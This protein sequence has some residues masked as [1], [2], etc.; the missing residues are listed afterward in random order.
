VWVTNADVGSDSVTRLAASDGT[1]IGT[2]PVG[3]NPFGVA[4]GGGHAWVANGGADTVTELDAATG[5]TL[6]TVTLPNGEPVGIALQG[7]SVW[8]ADGTRRL[9]RL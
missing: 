1:V 3:F 2:Y 8:V 4:V 9:V 5:R 7:T 6:R